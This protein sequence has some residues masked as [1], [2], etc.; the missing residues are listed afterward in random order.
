MMSSIKFSNFLETV[1]PLRIGDVLAGLR[2]GKNEQFLYN[3]V[4]GTVTYRVTQDAHGFIIDDVV[5]LS[6]STYVEAQANSA[7]NA[8]SVGMV[9]Q[10]VDDNTFDVTTSGHVSFSRFVLTPGAA[11][12]LDP[13]FAGN[14]TPVIPSDP[15]DI[16]KAILIADSTNTGI[17]SS[18]L[19]SGTIINAS[20]LAF[21]GN[22]IISTNANGPINLVPNGNGVTTVSSVLEMLNGKP[23]R[24]Y[25]PSNMFY[26]AFVAK[27]SLASNITWTLPIADGLANYVLETDGAGNLSFGLG[28]DGVKI[29]TQSAHG[30]VRGNVLGLSGTTYIKALADMASNANTAGMVL[31]VVDVDTFILTTCGFVSGLSGLTAGQYY[32]LSDVTPGTLMSTSPVT[33]GHIQKQLFYADTTTSGYYIPFPGKVIPNMIA[34]NLQLNGNDL[35]SLD[36]DGNVNIVPNGTGI[37]TIS[38]ELDLLTGSPLRWYNAAGTHYVAF[39]AQSGLSVDKTYQLPLADGSSGDVLTTN[40]SGVLSFTAP[41]AGSLT[42]SVITAGSQ[43]LTAGNGYEANSVTLT[44]FGLPTTAAVGSI[45]A[46]GSINT[47]G[48]EIIQGTGQNIT[49]FDNSTTVGASGA[50]FSETSNP[51]TKIIFI[52]TVANTTFDVISLMGSVTTT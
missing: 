47:G 13:D 25:E 3:G 16:V 33:V 4:D 35:L 34:T 5:R 29:I 37:T 7:T 11:Y 23:L 39:E 36:T 50:L 10:I 52:C 44:I 18:E 12:Y 19:V 6:G 46:V 9:T 49:V 38:S 22:D 1:T 24:W 51:T 45:Y 15:G 17:L 26:N 28:S 14:I 31:T 48:W 30:F 27:N 41:S 32:F 21:S 43:A 40:G 42:W 2:D 8:L 20:N